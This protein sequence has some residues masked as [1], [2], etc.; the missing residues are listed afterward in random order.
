MDPKAKIIPF[1]LLPNE[2]VAH[3]YSFVDDWQKFSLID[4]RCYFI[5]RQDNKIASRLAKKALCELPTKSDEKIRYRKILK[6]TSPYIFSLN[7]SRQKI[8]LNIIKKIVHFLPHLRGLNL[9]LSPNLNSE[10]LK[11]LKPLKQLEVLDIGQFI[12]Q[13]S[14]LI[15]YSSYQMPIQ[16]DFL[17]NHPKLKKLNISG[18][19]YKHCELIKL[20]LTPLLKE[21]NIKHPWTSTLSDLDFL[22]FIPKLEILKMG[23]GKTALGPDSLK[24]LLHTPKLFVLDITSTGFR[25][26]DLQY[27][28]CVPHLHSL[29][30]GSTIYK[31][32]FVS[33]K[34]LSNLKWTNKLKKLDL[35]ELRCS[36][37]AL[38]YISHTSHIQELSLLGCR[39]ITDKG[40]ECLRYTPNLRK[41]II[42]PFNY[43][44]QD[45]VNI[46]IHRASESIITDKGILN[47]RQLEYLTSLTF[48][49]CSGITKQTCCYLK[50]NK[51]LKSLKF[52][53]CPRIGSSALKK[54]EQL[55]ELK[56]LVIHQC[57]SIKEIKIKNLITLLPKTKIIYIPPQS[58]YIN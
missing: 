24:S 44:S 23:F 47:L 1:G 52:F 21:L 40:L 37:L 13:N 33:E 19:A 22:R 28:Q 34:N 38:E 57:Q 9:H 5:T 27:L 12:Y 11:H 48:V 29:S 50:E 45:I 4:R 39:N 30:I 25:G 54:L 32:N 41:L 36:N 26:P 46:A 3:I 16:L 43:Q 6:M 17:A 8:S 15:S 18:W 53:H 7:L 31:G 2:T 58:Y 49:C 10:M 42:G 35:N 55:T 51:K 14:S 56:K 20:R